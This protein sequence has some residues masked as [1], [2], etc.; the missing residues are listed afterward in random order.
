MVQSVNIKVNKYGAFLELTTK[1]KF[2]PAVLVNKEVLTNL[3]KEAESAL[4]KIDD[5]IE[6]G[7]LD[8]NGEPKCGGIK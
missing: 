7:I 4:V 8:K 6:V 1:R 3:I 5:L 2:M